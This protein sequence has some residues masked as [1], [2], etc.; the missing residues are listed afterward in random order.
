MNDEEMFAKQ[1]DFT[2]LN[3]YPIEDTGQYLLFGS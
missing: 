3:S 2:L 1:I